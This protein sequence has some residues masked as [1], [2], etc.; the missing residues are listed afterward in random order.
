MNGY[1]HGAIHH[2]HFYPPMMYPQH[3]MMHGMQQMP[4]NPAVATDPSMFSPTDAYNA[5][6]IMASG[7]YMGHPQMGLM[8][9]PTAL[10][11]SP[12]VPSTPSRNPPNEEEGGCQPQ[13]SDGHFDPHSTPYKYTPNHLNMSPYWGHLHDHATLSMMGL[14]SP[15]GASAPTTPHH[16]IDPTVSPEQNVETDHKNVSN[17]QPPFLRQQYYTYNPV[18][19]FGLFVTLFGDVAQM[20]HFTHCS[21]LF[22]LSVWK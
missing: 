10:V 18:R 2:Q 7:G 4:Y 5:H 20:S 9:H 14:C 6:F 15:T 19:T 16:G 8:G 22:I 13:Q 1:H 12:G 11:E 21:F 3:Q 17:A